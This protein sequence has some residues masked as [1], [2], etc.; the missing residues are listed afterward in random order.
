VGSPNEEMARK[1][2]SIIESLTKEAEVGEIYTGKVVRLTTF[3]A[4]VEI[5]PGKDGLVRL[6]D[7]DV[8][9][10]RRPEDAVRMGDEIMVMV[11]EVDQF[12]RINLSRRAVLEGATPEQARQGQLVGVTRGERDRDR[13]PSRGGFGGGGGGGGG[14][15]R[16]YGG[17][18]RQPPRGD[19]RPRPGGPGPGRPGPGG[20]G[21]RPQQRF[22]RPPGGGPPPQQGG[23]GGGFRREPGEPPPPPPPPPRPRW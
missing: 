9:P 13:G 23:G 10:V 11:I 19:S 16:P 3:G 5:L 14:G 22:R 20:G 12:G 7:L 15:R 2:I 18:D 4:F 6:E 1:A 8:E 21:G 17:G